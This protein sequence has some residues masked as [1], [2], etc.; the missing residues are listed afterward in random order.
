MPTMKSEGNPKDQH[1]RVDAGAPDLR[2]SVENFSYDRI[3]NPQKYIR[4]R[5]AFKMNERFKWFRNVKY[6]SNAA[7]EFPK[8]A[9][10]YLGE[11][12]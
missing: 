8:E 6:E 10:A 4:W 12:Q 3:R 7:L 1:R 5:Q 9:I 2:M 11:L